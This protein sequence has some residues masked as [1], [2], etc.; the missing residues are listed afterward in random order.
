MISRPELIILMGL[1]AALNHRVNVDN[2]YAR[3]IMCLEELAGFRSS[4]Q[5]GHHDHLAERETRPR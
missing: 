2:A 4:A 5:H 1:W 3:F